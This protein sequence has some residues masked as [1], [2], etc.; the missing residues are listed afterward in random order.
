MAPTLTRCLSWIYLAIRR[1]LAGQFA[2]MVAAAVATG[3][4]DSEQTD[5]TAATP[6]PVDWQQPGSAAVGH[7]HFSAQD[8]QTGRKLAMTLWYPADSAAAAAAKKGVSLATFLPEG[9]TRTALA[10]LLAKAP[11]ACTGTMGYS[12]QDAAPRKGQWPLVVYSHCHGC[13]RFSAALTAERLASHGIAVLA[14]DHAGNTLMEAQSGSSAPLSSAFLQVRARDI[15]FALD[16]ILDPAHPQ[17]PVALR[18]H[19]DGQRVGVCGHSFGAVTAGLV[20]QTDARVRAAWF[21]AAPVQNP[22][23][24]GVDVAQ[25][26]VPA[27]FLLAREDNSITALGNALILD[28]FAKIPGPAWLVEVADAGHWSFSE[29]AGLVPEF[30]AGCGPGER[31]TDGTPF[32]YLDNLLARQIAARAISAFFGEQL[33]GA[34]AARATLTAPGPAAVVTVTAKPK[35]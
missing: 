4:T 8:P 23:L 3:C 33:L 18:G 25:I 22:L 31:Q 9:A 16:V 12:A 24:A 10:E 20:A 34:T 7:A 28:N 30:A 6:A 5:P 21:V 13:T 1:T 35:P 29:L 32:V 19:S 11:A 27:G 17:L 2:V 15:R 14:V 26:K